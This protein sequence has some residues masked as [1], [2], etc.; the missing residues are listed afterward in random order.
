MG[1]KGACQTSEDRFWRQKREAPRPAVAGAQVV[2]TELVVPINEAPLGGGTQPSLAALIRALKPGLGID[3]LCFHP[4]SPGVSSVVL[5]RVFCPPDSVSSSANRAA[6]RIQQV[7]CAEVANPEPRAPE[8]VS[9]RRLPSLPT[10]VASFPAPHPALGV[11]EPR[12]PL[13]S[14]TFSQRFQLPETRQKHCS[15]AF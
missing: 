5:G 12:N 1:R 8:T 13:F 4:C 3:S 7:R 15:F 10:F 2:R 6:E 11:Q 9:T 14:S